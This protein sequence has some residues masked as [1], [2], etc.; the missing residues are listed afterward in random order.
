[1]KTTLVS[2]LL[3]VVLFITAR[4]Q[5]SN[6]YARKIAEKRFDSTAIPAAFKNYKGTLIV[7]SDITG[8]RD[9][10][11]LEKLMEGYDGKYEIVKADKDLSEDFPN[12]AK[13]CFVL[14]V[15]SGISMQRITQAPARES[16]SF[17]TVSLNLSNRFTK[18]QYKAAF[19][20]VDYWKLNMQYLLDMLNEKLHEK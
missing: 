5:N 16:Y 15:G 6:G 13:D 12:A 18:E 19:N 4:A 14:H 9:K 3:T 17:S 10:K 2:L 1:M 11:A 7:S 8:R 20:A